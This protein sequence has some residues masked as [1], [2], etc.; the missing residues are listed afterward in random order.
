MTRL[1]TVQSG[2]WLTKIARNVLGDETR[3]P[4]IAYANDLSHPY[5][6]YT[7]QVLELPDNDAPLQVVN[8]TPPVGERPGAAA[9]VTPQT[10][11]P[12]TLG[13]IVAVA[14]FLLWKGQK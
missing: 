10:L 9:A 2:D 12:A 7:G 6:I 8:P 14:A 4:E 3:W 1:Y 5:V 11:S 13:I